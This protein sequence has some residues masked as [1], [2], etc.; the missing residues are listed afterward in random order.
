MMG[1]KS[2]SGNGNNLSQP[3]Q[4]VVS[5]GSKRKRDAT[6]GVDEPSSLKSYFFAKFLTSPDLLD[7]E[8]CRSSLVP[9]LGH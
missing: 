9:H 5:A 2:A 1:N 3:T 6:E 8:V 4:T 7:L